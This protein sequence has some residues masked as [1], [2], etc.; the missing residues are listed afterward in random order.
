MVGQ[1]QVKNI[2]FP[3]S[4][5]METELSNALR[6][7]VPASTIP[8]SEFQTTWDLDTCPEVNGVLT[9]QWPTPGKNLIN[10][11]KQPSNNSGKEILILRT[12]QS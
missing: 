8:A 4:H 9:I 11:A 3:T 1:A 10:K 7:A 2:T 12:L 5:T 6:A